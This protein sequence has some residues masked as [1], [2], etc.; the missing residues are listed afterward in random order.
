MAEP[1]PDVAKLL[2]DLE[3]EECAL[4]LRR[5]RLHERIAFYPETTS[6]ELHRL[7]RLPQ[8]AQAPRSH[9][10]SAWCRRPAD[11]RRRGRVRPKRDV[12]QVDCL[13]DGAWM[14]LGALAVALLLVAFAF[15]VS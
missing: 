12:E 7:E 14:F 10:G 11:T 9:R 13:E 6:Q 2:A 8:A 5:H 15:I 3:A 4:S 1:S